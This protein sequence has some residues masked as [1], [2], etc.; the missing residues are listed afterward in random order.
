[1]P[2]KL[3]PKYSYDE[4]SQIKHENEFQIFTQYFQSQRITLQT[5]IRMEFSFQFRNGPD[6]KSKLKYIPD[7]ENPKYPAAEIFENNWKAMRP[8]P[9]KSFT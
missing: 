2:I 9:C 1:M 6:W 4:R 5:D 3:V 7:P 8:Y